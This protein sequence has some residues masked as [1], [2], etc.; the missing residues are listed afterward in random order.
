LTEE[1]VR[2]IRRQISEGQSYTA[3]GRELGVHRSTVRHVATGRCW[4]WLD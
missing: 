1:N 4:G 3:I 2:N